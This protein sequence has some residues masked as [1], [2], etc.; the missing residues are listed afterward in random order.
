VPTICVGNLSVGGAGK[1]PHVEYLI[2]LLQPYINTA[3]LSRGYR[4]KTQGFLF[5][6]PNLT[7]EDVGDEP[8]QYKRKYADVVVAVGERRAFAIPQ[9]L[10][11]Y[12]QVQVVL[13]DD[14]FQHLAV[15]PY[16][17]ILLTEYENPYFQDYWLPMGR[18]REG[19]SGAR[20]AQIVVVTKCPEDPQDIDFEYFRENL[21]LLPSQNLYFSYIRYGTPY[22]WFD[23]NLRFP[24][25]AQTHVFLFC[26][27]AKPEYL[28]NYLNSQAA[29]VTTLEF[30][31]HRFFTNYDIAQFKRLFEEIETPR[32][33][34]LT[35]EKDAV[36][37]DVHRAY[38][39][40]NNM[41]VF[42][43]PIETAFHQERPDAPTFDSDIKKYLLDFRI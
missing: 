38:I 17:S 13:L 36:R 29:L 3:V 32:K 25:D 14:A 42:I 8:L 35:T 7:A 22:S 39:E 18:L 9:I 26:A 4:R 23:A 10:Q 21:D 33:V 20:R 19:R 24:I 1:T 37:L 40:E 43:I 16:L 27:I 15:K 31:D 5:V 2:R 11:R 6:T 34:L 30:E 28:V 12:G 41:E